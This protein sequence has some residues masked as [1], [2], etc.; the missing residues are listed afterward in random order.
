MVNLHLPDTPLLINRYEDGLSLVP[1]SPLQGAATT[2]PRW[3]NLPFFLLMMS[4]ITVLLARLLFRR[5]EAAIYVGMVYLSLLAL[6]GLITGLGWTFQ[7]PLG[8]TLG[9]HLKELILSPLLG[10]LI[11]AAL[12]TENHL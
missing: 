11:L 7:L 6:A 2:D 8:Y 3:Y 9:Q 12:Y 1:A 5:K 4:G 10:L